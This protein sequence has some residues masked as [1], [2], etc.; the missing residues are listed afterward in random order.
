MLA[1]SGWQRPP[2]DRADERDVQRLGNA[3]RDGGADLAPSG[4]DISAHVVGDRQAALDVYPVAAELDTQ[5]ET[6]APENDDAALGMW[7]RRGV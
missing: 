2:G 6:A 4:R 5:A 7:P 1:Y 3:E